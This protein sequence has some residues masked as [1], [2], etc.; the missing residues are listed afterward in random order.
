MLGFCLVVFVVVLVGLLS[1]SAHYLGF[2]ICLEG[3]MLSSLMFVLVGTD[4]VFDFYMS[5]SLLVLAACSASL[6][7]ALLVCLLRS[8]GTGGVSLG[9]VG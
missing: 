8:G 9:D 2:L 4:F 1:N 6:G 5:L 7:L 3:L